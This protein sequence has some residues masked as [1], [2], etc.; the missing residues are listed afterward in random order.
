M[1][2]DKFSY[3]LAFRMFYKYGN[4]PF[5]LL[6]LFYIIQVLLSRQSDAMHIVFVILAV[7][8]IYLLN[9]KY[10]QSYKY[11]P[12]KVRIEN[13]KII[14]ENFFLSKKNVEI[15]FNEITQLKGGIFDGKLRG[16]IVII[17]E[18]NDKQF[19][20]SD[21][22]RNFNTLAAIILSKISKLLYDEVITKINTIKK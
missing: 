16:M 22:I 15:S 13:D 9:R 18:K 20:V 14:A 1:T 8:I 5:T 19:A 2:S 4:V 17:D 21:R 3:S 10:Y 7:S 11:L 6:L 12:G